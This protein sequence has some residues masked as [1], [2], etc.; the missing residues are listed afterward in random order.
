[1]VNTDFLTFPIAIHLGIVI[2]MSVFIMLV[3]S[4]EVDLPVIISGP[5][6]FLIA[7]VGYGTAFLFNFIIDVD[8]IWALA[9]QGV[10]LLLA[11]WLYDEMAG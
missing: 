1:M 7:L 3:L 8:M 2:T 9:F 5:L 4:Y 6:G 11:A 10:V